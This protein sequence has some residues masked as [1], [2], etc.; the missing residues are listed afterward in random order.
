LSLPPSESLKSENEVPERE[1]AAVSEPVSV[2]V[3]E[4]VPLSPRL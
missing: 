4:S 3:L 2:V 1:Y